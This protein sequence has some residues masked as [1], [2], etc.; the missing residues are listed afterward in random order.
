MQRGTMLG[1]QSLIFSQDCEMLLADLLC[2]DIIL[3]FEE[4]ILFHI[5]WDLKNLYWILRKQFPV[6][7]L[8]N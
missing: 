7:L 3:L 5:I 4:V 6:L 1:L 2:A 8:L